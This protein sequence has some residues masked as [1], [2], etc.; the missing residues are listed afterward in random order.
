MGRKRNKS[1]CHEPLLSLTSITMTYL[2]PNSLNFTAH[3][4]SKISFQKWDKLLTNAQNAELSCASPQF[5]CT[6]SKE[7]SLAKGVSIAIKR[8]PV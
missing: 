8:A 7:K 2:A 3:G 1:I 5:R 4:H 6:L